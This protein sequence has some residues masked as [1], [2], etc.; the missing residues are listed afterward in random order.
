MLSEP[1]TYQ[2]KMLLLYIKIYF[3]NMRKAVKTQINPYN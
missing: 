3:K 1:I 2:K